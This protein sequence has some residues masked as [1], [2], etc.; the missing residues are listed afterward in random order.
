QVA[1]REQITC[2]VPFDYTHKKQTGG[3]GQYG[4]VIGTL[5][6]S[7]EGEFLFN[8]EVR[9]GNIPREYIPSVEKGFRA[10]LEEGPFVGAPIHGLSVTLQDGAHHSVDSSDMAFQAAARGTFREFYP[11]GKP[12]V[13]EPI[14]DVVVEGPSEFQGEM[15]GT[16]LKRRGILVGTT[17]DSGFVRIEAE[18][19]LA[20]M[21]GYATTLRSATQGK[22]E[23]TMEFLR[24][25]P[26]PREVEE[27]LIARRRQKQEHAGKQGGQ[28]S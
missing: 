24:Y 18:A 22:A 25:A 19:P 26:A 15:V 12:Q 23:F 17:E 11:R 20:E 9:G 8:N 2:A 4:R 13:L 21:F 16:I 28:G 27:E 3:A 10:M 1:Y 7:E 14:M 5:A 6:P